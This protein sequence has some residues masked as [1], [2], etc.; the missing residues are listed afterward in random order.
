[1]DRRARPNVSAAMG[2]AS[3]SSQMLRDQAER[4]RDLLGRRLTRPSLKD[5]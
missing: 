3:K 4:C 2:D 1:M 5:C